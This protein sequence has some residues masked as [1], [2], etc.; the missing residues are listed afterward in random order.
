MSSPSASPTDF[1]YRLTEAVYRLQHV[2]KAENIPHGVV[3]IRLATE[4]D[5]AL[6]KRALVSSPSYREM[7]LNMFVDRRLEVCGARITWPETLYYDP[8]RR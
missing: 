8:P 6:F 2:L 7:M 1:C 4:K 3:E 5:G